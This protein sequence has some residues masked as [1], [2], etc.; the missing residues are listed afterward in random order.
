M[1]RRLGPESLKNWQR[2][3]R[4]GFFEKCLAGTAILDVRADNFGE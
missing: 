2:R 3:Q 1:E 4:E